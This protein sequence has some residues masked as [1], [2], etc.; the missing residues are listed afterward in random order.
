MTWRA[1]TYADIRGGHS[2]GPV[3]GP[4]VGPRVGP[5]VLKI[6]R[7]G[8]GPVFTLISPNTLHGAAGSA[9]EGVHPSAAANNHAFAGSY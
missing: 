1:I 4:G 8:P 3:A 9:V 7:T 2:T 5:E 6:F